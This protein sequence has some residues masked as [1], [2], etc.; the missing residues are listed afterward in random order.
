MIQRQSTTENSSPTVVSDT[1]DASVFSSLV[2]RWRPYLRLHAQRYIDRTIAARV[3]PSDL[4]QDTLVKAHANYSSFRGSTDG[5]WAFWLKKILFNEAQRTRRHHL[6]EKRSVAAER[7]VAPEQTGAFRCTQKKLEQ[8][9]LTEQVL[10]AVEQLPEPMREVIVRRVFKH[11]AFAQIAGEIDKSEGATRV[12]W[13]R[14]V[15]LLRDLLD[16]E[17]SN[18]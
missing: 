12:I 14:A 2:E 6:A 8:L 1:G 13:T 5:E 17:V 4:V 11:Q 3:D 18:E 9:E 16:A 15:K 7:A 10:A